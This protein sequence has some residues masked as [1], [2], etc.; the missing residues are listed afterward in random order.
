MIPVPKDTELIT[1][2]EQI[3]S[4]SKKCSMECPLGELMKNMLQLYERCKE[5]LEEEPGDNP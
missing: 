4:W 5:V 2:M 3:K 1:A